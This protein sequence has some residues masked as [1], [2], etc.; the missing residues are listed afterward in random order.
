MTQQVATRESGHAGS[1]RRVP[2]RIGGTERRT[3]GAT[4]DVFDPAT[5]AVTSLV[6][7]ADASVVDEAVAIAGEAWRTSW[8]E[9]SQKTRFGFL[10]NLRTRLFD[11][12]DDL[13]ALI[14]SEHGKSIPD[15]EGEFDRALDGLDSALSMPV[16]LQ[17][18]HSDQ[19]AT[20]VDT[21]SVLHPVGVAATVT[22]FNFPLMIP[23]WDAVAALACG[24]AVIHKPSPRV[25]SAA[26]LLAE[27]IDE[28]G[29]PPGVYNVVQG[30]AS[31]VN[32]LLDHPGVAA[33]SFVGSTPVAQHVYQ[34]G[35]A[36]GKRVQAMGGAKN[37]IV[38]MPDCDLDF[39]ADSLVSGAF[40]SSG[41]RCMAATVAVAVGDIAEPLRRAIAERIPTLRVGPGAAPETD[42]G[43]VVSR[44]SQTRILALIDQGEAEGIEVVVDGRPLARESDGFFVGPTLLDG[45][46]PGMAVY[47]QEIFGPVLGMTRV[48]TFDQALAMIAA[49]PY[50]N[51]ASVFTASG[52][53][54]RR[55]ERSAEVGM[56]GVNVPVPVPV[57]SFST[58][59]WKASVFGAHGL[60]GPEAFRFYSRQK[61]VTRRWPAGGDQSMGMAFTPG[62]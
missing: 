10:M 9:T 16:S 45:V 30:D 39:T 13:V 49:N 14:V 57:N 15:A 2:S 50:G 29:L 6:E 17:G 62:S 32:A 24:N 52:E 61:M 40:G 37:H 36:A 54:A 44:E 18:A 26:L 31:A 43:P 23:L 34:R 19:V 22:P 51:G 20:G 8:R 47:D 58:G 53:V 21:H 28:A 7:L 59:G 48:D 41:Q 35:C 38:V 42:M 46:R 11:R 12:R 33:I 55:F 27:I 60:L 3:G 1:E 25:P 5:G 4:A 56:V